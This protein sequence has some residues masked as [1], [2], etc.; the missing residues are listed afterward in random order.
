MTFQYIVSLMLLH[1]VDESVEIVTYSAKD[2]MIFGCIRLYICLSLFLSVFC[3]RLFQKHLF[4]VDGAWP[5]PEDLFS[6]WLTPRLAK[7]KK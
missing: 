6:F 2:V 3:L 5:K 7:E 4:S 1:V